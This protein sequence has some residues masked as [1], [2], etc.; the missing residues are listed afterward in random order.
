MP[1]SVRL[2]PLAFLGTALPLVAQGPSSLPPVRP[3]GAVTH[4]SPAGL[5][6]SVSSVRPLGGG[7]LLVNDIVRRRVVLLDSTF[8]ELAVVADTTP[9]TANAYSGRVAGLIPYA[10]DSTLFI[11]PGSLSMLVIAPSGEV[12]RV[13]AVPRPN[14]APFMVGGP[15][16]TPGFDPAGRIV[17]RGFARPAFRGGPPQ[18]GQPMQVPELPDSA[19]ILRVALATRTLDTIAHFKVPRPSASVRQDERGGMQVTMRQ[20]PLPVVDDWALLPDG[21]LAIVRGADYRVEYVAPDGARTGG[22]KIPFEWQRLSDDDKARVVDSA[23]KAMDAARASAGTQT[24]TVGGP[25]GGAAPAGGGQVMMFRFEGGPQGPGAGGPPRGGAP[26]SM[27]MPTIEMVPPSE[28]PDYRPAFQAGAVKA[29]PQGNLWVRTTRA[30]TAGPIYDVIGRDGTLRERVQLPAN[31]VLA[32]FGAGVAYLGV[33]D[34]SGARL[35]VARLR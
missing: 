26:T 22:A 3:L 20:H 23:K 13:M 5:L 4:V 17:Y 10:G 24:V 8:R 28:L 33:R 9:A 25:A 35:E 19:P 16:G 11:D 27:P 18:P 32:G 7:R 1:S 14:D 34:E 21:T 31:R 6:G 12:A 15:F 30:S 2:L 29:D